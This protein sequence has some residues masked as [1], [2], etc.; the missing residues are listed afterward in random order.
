V[1]LAAG[2]GSASARAFAS[3]K[4]AFAGVNRVTLYGGAVA[5]ILAGVAGGYLIFPPRPAPPPAPVLDAVSDA[6]KAE[7]EA[8]RKAEAEAQ[9]RAEA[10]AKQ[11][12]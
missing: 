3:F 12:A 9:Q 10:E 6:A 11:K 4:S 7:A 2:L 1:S 8:R 5:A